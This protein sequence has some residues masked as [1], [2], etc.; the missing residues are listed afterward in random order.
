M[1]HLK[2]SPAARAFAA[3]GQVEEDATG[4][5]KTRKAAILLMAF[6]TLMIPLAWAAPSGAQSPDDSV[7]VVNKSD[8][9]DEGDSDDSD[10]DTG[11]ASETDGESDSGLGGK[12]DRGGDTSANNADTRGTTAGTGASQTRGDS[13]T[14][15]GGKTDRGGDTSA[16]N[17]D[18]RGTT[19]GTGA[20]QTSGS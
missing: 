9:G 20:S 15:L 13:D 19:A 8:D 14:G 1:M 11:G 10:E 4:A 16:N 12:T 3:L 7:A 5:S 2:I 6:G 17:A 18:T